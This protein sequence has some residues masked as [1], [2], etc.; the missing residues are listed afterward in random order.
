MLA[1][2]LSHYCKL[3]PAV[4]HTYINWPLANILLPKHLL[5][6]TLHYSIYLSR[7][8]CNMLYALY[9]TVS[10]RFYI[11]YASMYQY[12]LLLHML[13]SQDIMLFKQ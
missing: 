7:Y 10:K 3:F 1:L 4:L 13:G 5:T 8:I 12:I 2:K 11:Y 6:N 9:F